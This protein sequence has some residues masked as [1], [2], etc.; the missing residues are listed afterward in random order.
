MVTGFRE[1][2][3]ALDK[4]YLAEE[5]A[6]EDSELVSHHKLDLCYVS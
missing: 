5:L 3:D 6:E 4:E 1:V 2:V